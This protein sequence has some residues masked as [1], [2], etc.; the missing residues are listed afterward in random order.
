M[1][2]PVVLVTGASAGIGVELAR[3]AARDGH[4]LIL[5]ARRA[6]RL[7]E[8]AIELRSQHGVTVQT[9]ALDL[10]APGAAR[11]LL[12]RCGSP[13]GILVN[14]AGFGA[15]SA[16]A[17]LPWERQREMVQLN[18]LALMEL[19]HAVLPAMILARSGRILNV[20][21]TAGFTA[22][23]FM[24]TYY[25]TKHFVLAWSEAL[26]HEVKPHGIAVSALCPG[27]TSTEFAEVASAGRLRLFNRPGIADAASV[28]RAGWRGLLANRAIVVPGLMN[29]L[30]I[31]ALRF[32]PR[33]LARRVVARLNRIES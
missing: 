22:G 18:V 29:R 13:P 14:N 24:A 32:V 26:H 31:L 17:D 9:V 30:L 5:T 28:A 6:D 25:A 16:I 8:L 3:C 7:E 11:E 15:L 4:P 20:A 27:P 1:V 10:A 23:P 33:F 12:A 2:K 19:T 21:S